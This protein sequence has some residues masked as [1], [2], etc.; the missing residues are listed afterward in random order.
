MESGR[1]G[2]RPNRKEKMMRD[3]FAALLLALTMLLSF[4]ACSSVNSPQVSESFRPVESQSTP[5]PSTEVL[6]PQYTDS[7]VTTITHE[8]NWIMV[9]DCFYE[10]FS[11]ADV[12]INIADVNGDGYNDCIVVDKSEA[13]GHIFGYVITAGEREAQCQLIY[14]GGERDRNFNWFL[15]PNEQGGA[16]LIEYDNSVY[17]GTGTLSL[18]SYYLNE[19]GEKVYFDEYIVG[20]EEAEINASGFLKGECLAEFFVVASEKLEGKYTLHVTSPWEF[21]CEMQKIEMTIE[22]GFDENYTIIY[23]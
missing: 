18:R 7:P 16:Y 8:G 19:Y 22:M 23:R 21:D 14:E 13:D 5:P 10:Y 20:D 2:L 15:S 12:S 3:K 6:E 4:I 1:G 17:R 9:S 11:G